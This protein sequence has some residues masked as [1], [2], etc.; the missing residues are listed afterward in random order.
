MNPIHILSVRTAAAATRLAELE[1]KRERVGG[2]G[3]RVS[4]A[5]VRE[6]QGAIEMLRVA[7]DQLN[8][9]SDG[10]ATAR[11]AAQTSGVRY[12]EL[13]NALPTACVCTDEA[14]TVLEANEAAGDLFNI[15]SRHLK[16]KPLLLFIADRDGFARQLKTSQPDL[17][18]ALGDIT[19]RPRDRKPRRIAVQ[20]QHL[21]SH[22]C[23]CWFFIDALPVSPPR[24]SSLN[25]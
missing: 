22:G 4:G 11:T 2:D 6:L 1:E 25:A 8:E 7:V 5:A 20:V 10:L 14:G 23:R 24:D 15:S 18:P 12:D 21:A 13:W 9:L 19:I 17:G 3:S 16:G